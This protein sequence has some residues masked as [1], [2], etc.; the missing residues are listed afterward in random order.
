[1]RRVADDAQ[2]SI[3]TGLA[4]R[5]IDTVGRRT[6]LLRT[7]P[8]MAVGMLLV[9]FS[10]LFLKSASDEGIPDR[11]TAW[12]YL[13]VLAMTSFTCSYALGLGHVVWVVQSEIF[14]PEVRATGGALA[15]GT[16]VR[17]FSQFHA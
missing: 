7:L 2:R 6:L 10:F 1:M 17:L 13:S 11:A 14:T 12:S 16:N 5:L 3:C 15:T 8:G 9:G 4:L